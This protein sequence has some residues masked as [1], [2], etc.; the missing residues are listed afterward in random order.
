M[1]RVF[2]TGA[3]TWT[4]GNLIK[5]LEARREVEVYAVDDHKP[6][7]DFD[8]DFQQ[9]SLD[10]LALARYV[11]EVEPTIVVH[12]Q[13]VHH[14]SEEGRNA[15]AEERIVGALALFGAIERL[16]SVRSVVVK[17][18]TAIYGASPRNPSVLAESTR[19]QGKPSRYQRDLSE[20][21]RFIGEAARRHRNIAFTT[22]RF[23]PIF[24]PEVHNPISR[25]LA[26]PIVPTLMGFDP[27]L[28]FIHEQDAVS[29]LEHAIDHPRAGTFNIAAV[30]QMYLSRVLRLGRRIPQPLPGRA[31]DTALRGLTRFNVSTP[32][33]LKGLL[34]HGRVVDT[35]RMRDDLSFAPIFTC[36]QTV[37]SAYGSLE[38]HDDTA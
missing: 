35:K 21:E 26:L 4:G 11:L 12:L 6:R 16:S 7:V 25:Y 30:G 5:R 37:L 22:L 23:A 13:S 1:D 29:A 2:V 15:E 38:A 36:R 19:P 28:Q 8:S 27:R 24:G 20:M 31:F 14:R 9:L 18:D 17:S 34:K 10:R 32:D 33:H 3:A